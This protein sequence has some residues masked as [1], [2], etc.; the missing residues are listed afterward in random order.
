MSRS[1]DLTGRTTQF[2]GN[3]KH[4]RGSSGAGGVWRFKSTRTSRTWQPNLRK[5]RVESNGVVETLKVSMKA[6]KKLRQGAVLSGYK[7]A[8]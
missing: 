7:L 4:K 8:A 5:V 3:R 6:Y 1:C 2:G